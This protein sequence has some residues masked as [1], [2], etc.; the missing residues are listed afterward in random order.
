M[1]EMNVFT[2][3][4][5]AERPASPVETAL[6]TTEIACES[7]DALSESAA[8]TAET[9]AALTDAST[10]TRFDKALTTLWNP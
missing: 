6:E 4:T 1:P 2:E 3:L 8:L 9:D 10:E 5:L 7:A